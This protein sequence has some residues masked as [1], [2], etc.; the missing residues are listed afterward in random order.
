MTYDQPL[1]TD[2][3]TWTYGA[4]E[5]ADPLPAAPTL[6]MIQQ[7]QSR[8]CELPAADLIEL[9]PE[10]YF[11]DGMYGR[12]LFIPAGTVIVGKIHRHEH[13]VQLISGE[14]TI[15]TDGQ[16]ERVK[17]FRAW[18]SPAGVKRAIVTHTDCT[19]FTVHLNASNS[20]DLD[21]IEEYVIVPEPRLARDTPQ[22]SDLSD[23]IQGVFA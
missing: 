18:T 17:G 5:L 8:M 2:M 9:E 11:A 14:A 7:L 13:L 3:G 21:A 1:S 16:R 12:E 10:H 6:D 22:L 20:R 23:D 4:Q 15:C 19:F